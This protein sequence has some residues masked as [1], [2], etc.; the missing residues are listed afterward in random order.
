[1]KT[2]WH[3]WVVGLV[4]LIWHAGGAYD[5]LMTMTRN[6][7]YL[8]MIPEPDRAAVLA[9]MDSMPTWAASTWALGV[10]AAVAGSLLILLRSRHAFVAFVLALIGLIGTNY[11]TLA[12]APA[13]PMTQMTPSTLLFTAAILAVLLGALV[14]SRWQ[15]RAGNLR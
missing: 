8:A 7:G 14:Y 3:I 6:A 11:Y 4:T 15:I 13:S 1:M 2:P 12:L 9:Y 10:W 5:Y